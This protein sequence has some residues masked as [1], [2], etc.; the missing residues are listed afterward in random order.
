MA[1]DAARL[2]LLNH[3]LNSRLARFR[4]NEPLP[5]AY[6]VP[7]SKEHHMSNLRL[8][9]V[10]G[11]TREGRFGDK[12][13]NWFAD[14]A[15]AH[16]GFD[17]DVIDLVDVPLTAEGPA[18]GQLPEQFQDFA[19]RI[20]AAD[21]FVFSTPEYNH[22]YPASLKSALDLLGQQ[23]WG[24]PCTFLGYG[25]ISGGIRAIEQLRPVVGELHM[26]D[27]REAFIAPF[28]PWGFFD[29][30]TGEVTD[31]DAEAT[32]AAVLNR[33]QWWAL[34]LSDARKARPFA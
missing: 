19:D 22:G 32:V 14:H 17:V 10:I 25:G 4:A 11:S 29:K 9:I 27:I 18:R 20:A 33:L 21:A 8:A 15:R 13:T 16:G 2:V 30:E 3:Q 31:P 12:I 28:G 5:A 34:A 23:W 7:F 26:A 24:K 1:R 6:V